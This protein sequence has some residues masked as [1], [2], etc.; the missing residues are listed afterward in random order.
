MKNLSKYLSK[1]LMNILMK[2]GLVIALIFILTLTMFSGCKKTNTGN[3]EQD[4]GSTN[5]IASQK[6]SSLNND[7]DSGDESNSDSS[8]NSYEI[9]E[10]D[11][12]QTDADM[13]TD[14]DYETQY[15]EKES[16]YIQ[17]NGNSVTASSN[18]VKISGSTVTI[19]EDATHIISG[20]LEDGMIIVNAP[21]TAKLQLVFDGVN[22]TSKTSA[23]LY[24]LEAD[25]VFVTLAEGSENILSNGGTFTPID[26]NNIDA[27]IFSKQDITFN[28]L[29]KL[30]V[31]SPSGHGIVSKDDLVITS[32]T[33]IVSSASH[34]LNA[35]DSLRITD[36]S[37]TIDAGKDGIH[38]EN[39]E[40]TT[41]GYIYISSGTID[42]E[43]EGDGISSELYMHILD[44]D[45][46]VITGGGSENGSKSSSDS[47]GGFRGGRPGERP[48][49]T[50]PSDRIPSE[51]IS[52]E[53]TTEDSSTSMKG[54]KSNGSI[55]ISNGNININSA[56]DSVHS[57]KSVTVNGGN[58]EI[59]SGDDAIHAEESL[60]ITAGS[61]NITESYEGLEAM[62]IE[63]MGGDIKLVASDD[64]LNAAGGTDS[65][66]MGGRD[67]M[68]GGGHG[69]MGG[70]M[71]TSSNGSVVISGGTLY[72][73]SSGDGI[74]SNGKLTISG[75]HITVVGPTQG[76]TAT[77]DYDV[78]GVITGGTFIGT[79]ASSGMAQTFSSSEQGV[80]SINVGNQ[81]AGTNITL[82]D[83]DGNTIISHEPELSFA[84][85][86]LSSP[87]LIKGETYSVTVG[88][89]S[90][91]FE[92][93]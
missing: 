53:T 5:N 46:D 91:E 7:S 34:G 49:E 37:I 65:S 64:G 25:K 16:I 31:N 81:S 71:S 89:S 41:V 76:D 10:V 75:G 77:L 40:D 50:K 22:I 72:I 12:S 61:I 30:T 68:F 2:R 23:P 87:E 67:A 86:I 55:L 90:G 8:D 35:N 36:A 17:L 60:A 62:N 74:D 85:V 58:I 27:A 47:W 44:G 42:I 43:A 18:S 13:F 9:L 80:V 63:V 3:K 19:T 21:D 52:S 26:D 38:A 70:G 14:R 24:I 83:K 79:G 4:S 88:S 20:T 57:N 6:D 33:Y 56:D 11:F 66:G 15:D 45:I 78:S 84:V 54:I 73:N 28:G 29:G 82:K 92:A 1:N 48:N 32:G 59:A 69:G 93:S 39:S 51:T